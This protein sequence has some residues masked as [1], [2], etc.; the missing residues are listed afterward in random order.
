MNKNKLV[1]TA[2]TYFDCTDFHGKYATIN[3]T[4]QDVGYA[5]V[6][7]VSSGKDFILFQFRGR[8]G[9]AAKTYITDMREVKMTPRALKKETPLTV[10]PWDEDVHPFCFFVG[11]RCDIQL[12][13]TR[14]FEAV[15]G[16]FGAR[17]L[18]VDQQNGLIRIK[19]NGKQ[20]NV[21]IARICGLMQS[22]YEH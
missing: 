22:A 15:P 2:D 12:H 6:G 17:I 10:E 4:G 21:S 16:F 9:L 8:R 13:Q 3:M 7:I 19:E 5:R 20:F 14:M 18:Y 1:H 11:E